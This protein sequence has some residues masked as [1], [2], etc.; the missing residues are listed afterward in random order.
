MIHLVDNI[1]YPVPTSQSINKPLKS[2][3]D[4][5]QV[6]IA[7]E[8]V[9]Q[10]QQPSNNFKLL[11]KKLLNSINQT[12]HKSE[13][14]FDFLEKKLELK[15]RQIQD[16]LEY[17]NFNLN[18][19][20]ELL[21]Y[22]EKVTE[23]LNSSLKSLQSKNTQVVQEL[24][25]VDWQQVLS[26]DLTIL[27]DKLIK[28]LFAQQTNFINK[29]KTYEKNEASAW[30]AYFI[31]NQQLQRITVNSSV[32][33]AITE[34]KWRAIFICFEAKLK[35]AYYD[36]CI[37]REQDL[38]EQ[39]Q[40]YYNLLIK[41]SEIL[42][43]LQESLNKK[44]ISSLQIISLPAFMYLNEINAVEQKTE[45]ENWVGHSLNHW[46]LSAISWQEIEKKLL[47]NLESK[48][49]TMYQDFCQFFNN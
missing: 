1:N 43:H 44:S 33:N 9:E 5:W 36:V 4:N 6:I 25:S 48:V 18:N 3:L 16:T 7:K 49:L 26:H 8:I 10:W 28:I 32:Y 22:L 34:S 42:D 24:V 12:N 20:D 45:I 46:G 30:Q 11:E 14:V 19:N 38:I 47:E 41:S 15:I 35:V 13:K 37:E 29:K 40:T 31:L 17:T 39:L 21:N 2:L 23:K 27:F